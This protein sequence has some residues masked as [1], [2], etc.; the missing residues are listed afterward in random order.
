MTTIRNNSISFDVSTSSAEGVSFTH[1]DDKTG[2]FVYS[3]LQLPNTADSQHVID[4]EIYQGADDTEERQGI[5]QALKSNFYDSF[6]TVEL[7]AASCA[8]SKIVVHTENV[9]IKGCSFLVAFTEDNNR[10]VLVESSYA[11]YY[12]VTM[13]NEAH[14]DD[15]RYGEDDY[16]SDSEIIEKAQAKA[17][18]GVVSEIESSNFDTSIDDGDL[19]NILSKYGAEDNE[20]SLTECFGYDGY[21]AIREAE[22]EANQKIA[23][24]E[25]RKDAEYEAWAREFF[26]NE[27]N[28]E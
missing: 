14:D 23:E 15:Y 16:L 10:Y 12:N 22:Q 24:E 2:R 11:D 4:D 1:I 21:C 7:A 17:A 8:V 5:F 3:Y 20:E 25:E 9:Y 19:L 26:K 28:G 6:D 18:E 27:E 13:F